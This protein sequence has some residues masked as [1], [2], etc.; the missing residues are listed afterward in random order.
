MDEQTIV[1]ALGEIANNLGALALASIHPEDPMALPE[2]PAADEISLFENYI[3]ALR[4]EVEADLHPILAMAVRDY[5]AGFADR[6]GAYLIDFVEKLT[7][8]QTFSADAQG[9]INFSL[10]DLR[11]L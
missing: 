1:T 10:S 11:E 6:A 2:P 9:K 4:A 7:A 8:S 3:D 5:S